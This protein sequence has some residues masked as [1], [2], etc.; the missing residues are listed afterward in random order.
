MRN[1][2]II[3]KLWHESNAELDNE[4]FCLLL[5]NHFFKRYNKKIYHIKI[6]FTQHILLFSYP[7]I[8]G[9]PP[10]HFIGCLIA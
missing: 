2:A 8:S 9:I 10:E 4:V 7:N 1:C 6:N 3:I 5:W